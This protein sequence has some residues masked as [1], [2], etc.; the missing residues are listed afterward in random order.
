MGYTQQGL[1]PGEKVRDVIIRAYQGDPTGCAACG[2]SESCHPRVSG[3]EYDALYG[4]R[5]AA[6]PRPDPHG[7]RPFVPQYRVLDYAMVALSEAYL[8]V[9]TISTG[10]VWAG[11]AIVHMTRGE[12]TYKEMSEEM[13][14]GLFR[15]PARILDRLTPTDNEYAL[16]WR[17][18]C[19]ERLSRP[20]V[21]PGVLVTFVEPLRFNNGIETAGPF[22]FVKGSTFER[23]D[24]WG[25]Y[26]ISGW[27][28]LAYTAA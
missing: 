27:R 3:S 22:R 13:G 10:E 6:E 9:E 15:C 1:E 25:R 11:V 19:R 4:P 7:Y 20:K 28:E 5:P 24:G 14:P 21:A 2:W 12:V 18:K 17:A 16:E 8:A 23:A 26:R